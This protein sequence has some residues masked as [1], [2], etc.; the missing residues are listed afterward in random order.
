M[1]WF[2][3]PSD[4]IDDPPPTSFEPEKE[5]GT[6]FEVRVEKSIIMKLIT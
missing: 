3:P 5:R 1:E 4:D 2:F 6:G